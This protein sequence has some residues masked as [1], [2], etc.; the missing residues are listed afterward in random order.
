MFTVVQKEEHE[1]DRRGEE[2]EEKSSS[3]AVNLVKS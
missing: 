1:G 3:K 2:R